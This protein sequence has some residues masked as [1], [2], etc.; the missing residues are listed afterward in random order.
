M[1]NDDFNKLATESGKPARTKILLHHFVSTIMKL[2]ERNKHAYIMYTH[3]YNEA[4]SLK[5]NC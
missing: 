3:T 5:G 4:S 1:L 2:K